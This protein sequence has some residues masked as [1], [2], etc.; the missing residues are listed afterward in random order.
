[1]LYIILAL[2]SVAHLERMGEGDDAN[3]GRLFVRGTGP[4]EEDKGW[5]VTIEYLG[6]ARHTY[7][8]NPFTSE[9]E[10]ALQW[11][12]ERYPLEDPFQGEKASAVAKSI[13]RY[14]LELSHQLGLVELVNDATRTVRLLDVVIFGH[15][16]DLSIHV[17]HWESLGCLSTVLSIPVS[18]RRVVE[19]G[20]SS[21][22]EI[23]RPSRAVIKVLFVTA[24]RMDP[25]NA[26]VDPNI[27]LDSILESFPF[28]DNEEVAVTIVRP[29]T[30]EALCKHLDP[31]GLYQVV[32]FDLHG[33]LKGSRS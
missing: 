33:F 25:S 19:S 27:M 26:D 12:L 13:N 5:P 30:F 11:Y 14:S 2:A 32:H 31:P 10:S 24:R 3:G 8:R 6:Q 18:V 22:D 1:M 20:F 16:D 9:E 17:L 29:G 23:A 7:V 15:Q 4:L 28:Q 21:Q